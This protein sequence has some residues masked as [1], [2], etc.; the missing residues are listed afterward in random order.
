MSVEF[1]MLSSSQRL[2]TE[3]QELRGVGHTG[4]RSGRALGTEARA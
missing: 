2:G 4:H 1:E 3:F